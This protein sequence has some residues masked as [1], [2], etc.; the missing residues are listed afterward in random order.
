[1][2]ILKTTEL[3]TYTGESDYYVKC[4]SI[5]LFQNNK[6]KEIARERSGVLPKAQGQ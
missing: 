4:I 6:R 2:N 5:K 3:Y 1:M